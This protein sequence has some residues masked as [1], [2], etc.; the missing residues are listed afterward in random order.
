MNRSEEGGGA[1]EVDEVG[2]IRGSG[3]IRVFERGCM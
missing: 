1:K 3:K 2:L